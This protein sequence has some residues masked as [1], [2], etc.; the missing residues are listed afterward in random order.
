MKLNKLILG[1]IGIVLVMTLVSAALLSAF[2]TSVSIEKNRK[3]A[4]TSIG[5][6]APEI[7]PLTCD[8]DNCRTCMTDKKEVTC[9]FGD[10]GP[11]YQKVGAGCVAIPQKYC[12]QYSEDDDI[13]E[14][15]VWTDYTQ[16]ELETMLEEAVKQRLEDIA[17]ATIERQAKA[18]SQKTD[19][20]TITIT[21]K[22]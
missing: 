8:G 1:V 17:D 3:T 10:V 7:A 11:C 21:E 12:S 19:A 9:E 15:N 4:L 5:I 18:D 2:N 6:T 22:K 14:C 20:G 16:Q 13:G